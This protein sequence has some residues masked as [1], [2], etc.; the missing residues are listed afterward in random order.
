MKINVEVSAEQ[1]AAL[2]AAAA[3]NSTTVED[4]AAKAMAA[5]ADA[6]IIA[7][8]REAIYAPVRAAEAQGAEAVRVALEAARAEEVKQGLASSEGP[9]RFGPGGPRG[10][11]GMGV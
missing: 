8:K 1:G 4:M 3:K 7:A 6:L 9:D 11:R 2:Q 10:R 5:Q